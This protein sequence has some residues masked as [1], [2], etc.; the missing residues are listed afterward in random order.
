MDPRPGVTSPDSTTTL[1]HLLAVESTCTGG[2]AMGDRL[3][4]PQVLE[5]ADRVRIVFAAI[6]LV[7]AQDCPSNPPTAV[8]ITLERPL[9]DRVMVDG[10][11]IGPLSDLA[12]PAS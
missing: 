12:P 11:V 2:R 10:L 3:L 5:T 9:G 4:G 1:I 7:G 8:T 6:A